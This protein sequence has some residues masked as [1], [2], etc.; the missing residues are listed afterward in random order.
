MS[1]CRAQNKGICASGSQQRLKS[2]DPLRARSWEL[3][4]AEQ[5]QGSRVKPFSLL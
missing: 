5:Q 1:Q 3:P 4:Q 2:P